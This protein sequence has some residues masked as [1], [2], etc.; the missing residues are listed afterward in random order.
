MASRVGIRAEVR[1][2]MGEVIAAKRERVAGDV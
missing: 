2:V 1:R